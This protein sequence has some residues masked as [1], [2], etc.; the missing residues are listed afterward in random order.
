M[1]VLSSKGFTLIEIMMVSA[2]ASI[3]ALMG[4]SALLL[5]G[6]M[7]SFVQHSA[8]T[9]ENSRLLASVLPSYLGQALEIDWSN[10]TIGDIGSGRG[11]LRLFKSGV[12]ISKPAP[13]PIGVFLRETGRPSGG[14]Q[15]SDLRATGFYF[16]NPTPTTP[17]ELI[18]ASSPQG[19]G[20][21]V[22]TPDQPIQSFDSIVQLTLEPT[23]SFKASEPA[24][25][26]VKMSVVFRKFI[27]ESKREWRWCPAEYIATYPQCKTMASYRDIHR[28]FHIP[29]KNNA[30]PTDLIRVDGTKIKETLYGQLYFYRLTTERK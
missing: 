19:T 2:V 1:R 27:S 20:D 3:I 10:N 22:L 23:D 12:N 9:E 8:D 15:K 5:M 7:G 21:I 16:R 4:V 26:S 30:L 25:R 18:I 11:Q 24:V 29:L 6:K 14:F 17:G 28:V 13:T